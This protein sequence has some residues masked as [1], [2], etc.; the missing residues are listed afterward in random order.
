VNV[1][2]SQSDASLVSGLRLRIDTVLHGEPA[3]EP[4]TFDTFFDPAI[5]DRLKATQPGLIGLPG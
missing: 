3:P 1:S 5:D 2:L 4:V